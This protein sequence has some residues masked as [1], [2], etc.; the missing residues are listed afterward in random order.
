MAATR[1]VSIKVDEAPQRR[2]RWQHVLIYAMLVIFTL[3]SL[4]PFIFSVLSS[5]KTF[6]DILAF[7]P[8]LFPPVWTLENYQTILTGGDMPR[9][10]LNSF[11]FAVGVMILNIIFSA[12]AGYALSRMRFRGRETI[13]LFTLAVM[14]IPIPVIIIPKFLVVNSLHLTNNFIG[15]ILPMMAQPFSVFLFVQFMKQLPREMEESAMIDGASRWRTFW[16]IIM[17]LMQPAITAV[18]ILSFQGAWNEFIWSLLVL[19]TKDMYTLPV[20]L[21][22]Y[23]QA[24]FTEYNLLITS[25]MFNTIPVLIL[26]FLFQR[27]F[28]EGST[29]AA[30]KG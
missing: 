11:I 8:S 21:F 15:L 13:F 24:H 7:P 25:S 19:D 18:A 26:F 3:S 27:Y 22:Q 30:V 17:P 16:Q 2:F 4:G 14:M 23:K 9:W 5:F 20:G 28:I 6:H 10:L 12:M 1:P 29:A